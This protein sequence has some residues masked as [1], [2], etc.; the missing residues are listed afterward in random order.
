M[1]FIQTSPRQCGSWAYQQVC[2]LQITNGQRARV[3]KSVCAK[4]WRN[5]RG[6]CQNWPS[7]LC[8]AKETVLGGR[9]NPRN[10]CRN[11]TQ[12]RESFDPPWVLITVCASHASAHRRGAIC[13]ILSAG[14][15][16]PFTQNAQKIALTWSTSAAFPKQI[17]HDRYLQVQEENCYW[18]SWSLTGSHVKWKD[19]A[20][21][22]VFLAACSREG[23]RGIIWVVAHRRPFP[24][25]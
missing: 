10:E 23:G 13:V 19:T 1:R 21:G 20:E 16:R 18:N 17:F 22:N 7:L 14:V 25:T 9:P 12:W 5:S 15:Q 2:L 4:V 8:P 3:T 11:I 6:T 24:E